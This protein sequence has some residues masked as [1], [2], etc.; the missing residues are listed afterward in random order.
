MKFSEINFVKCERDTI[1][2][3]PISKLQSLKYGFILVL[4]VRSQQRS[5]INNRATVYVCN[6]KI[7]GNIKIGGC[8]WYWDTTL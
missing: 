2:K 1:P 4:K 6:Q 7:A 8:G 5:N 3:E